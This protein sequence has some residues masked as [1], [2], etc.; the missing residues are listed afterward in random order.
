MYQIRKHDGHTRNTT[1]N[2]E[3]IF[4][5]QLKKRA[6]EELSIIAD[7]WFSIGATIEATAEIMFVTARSGKEL[8]YRI[9]KKG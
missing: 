2:G 4:R 3:I 7:S 8:T 6:E 5:T 1:T 9:S